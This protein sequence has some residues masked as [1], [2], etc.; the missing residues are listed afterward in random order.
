MNSKDYWESKHKKYSTLSWIDKPTVFVEQVIKYLPPKGT[1]LEL[2]AGQGQDSRYLAKK[3]YEVVSTD[4]SEYALSQSKEK[5]QKEDIKLKLLQLDMAEKL[6]FNDQEFDSVYSHLALHYW[7]EDQTKE[8]FKEIYRVLKP[9]G[10][11]AALFNSDKDPE[12]K[13][14]EK[15]GKNLY[16]EPNGT[17]RSY[18]SANY[19][20]GFINDKFE[21]ILLDDYGTTHKDAIKTLTRFVGRKV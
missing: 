8:I 12:I 11:L 10:V 19:L 5:A 16:M 17:V 3:G 20:K 2:G 7:D 14:F 1:I 18:W 13:D 21:V 9:G 4:F 15:V 6:P